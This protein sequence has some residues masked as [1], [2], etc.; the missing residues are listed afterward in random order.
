M[1]RGLG[2]PLLLRANLTAHS[3]QSTLER[4]FGEAKSAEA[5][6]V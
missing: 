1:A 4:S 6:G 5:A 2:E 3:G